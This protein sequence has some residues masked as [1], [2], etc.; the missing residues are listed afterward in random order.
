MLASLAAA[1]QV[2]SAK[3]LADCTFQLPPWEASNGESGPFRFALLFDAPARGRSSISSARVHDP[4]GMLRGLPVTRGFYSNG[5]KILSFRTD[6]RQPVYFRIGFLSGQ[7][8]W[9]GA[10]QLDGVATEEQRL[11]AGYM[12][13]CTIEALADAA[14]RFEALEAKR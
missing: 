9:A 4:K 8:G 2:P 6:E 14:A 12:G 7:S 13:Q 1:A 11:A 3:T 10:I 5:G